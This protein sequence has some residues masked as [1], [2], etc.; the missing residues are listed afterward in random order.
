MLLQEIIFL[1]VS[2]VIFYFLYRAYS[3]LTDLESC[4]CAPV[5]Y[6]TNLRQI[7]FIYLAIVLFGILFKVIFL[8]TD[9]DIMDSLIKNTSPIASVAVVAYIIAMFFIF[10]WYMYN[11]LLYQQTLDGKCTCSNGWQNNI[12][13]VH[14]LY[15]ALPIIMTMLGVLYEFKVNTSLLV[16]ILIFVAVIYLYENYIIKSGKAKEGYASMLGNYEESDR[17]YQANKY[18][19][20]GVPVVPKDFSPSVAQPNQSYR[21][22][23]PDE[24]V[25]KSEEG[26]IY[27]PLS[28]HENIVRTLRQKLN[29]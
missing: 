15:M 5:P 26:R 1:F 2:F 19:E 24:Y 4:D 22:I 21:Q 27:A 10:I 28:T 11:V 16:I 25:N 13:Y 17:V 29:Y 9:F 3:Y 20:G 14:A 6:V 7:E 12:L 18:S 23:R 8:L